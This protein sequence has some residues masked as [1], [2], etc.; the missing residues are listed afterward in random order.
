MVL[1]TLDLLG[2]GALFVVTVGA[3]GAWCVAGGEVIGAEG[4]FRGLAAEGWFAVLEASGLVD[5]FWTGNGFSGAVWVASGFAEVLDGSGGSGFIGAGSA[6][7][8]SAVSW[9]S[10]DVAGSWAVCR[11]TRASVPPTASSAVAPAA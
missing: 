3:V 9:V 10:V 7:G 4:G 2:A 6:L 1:N 11:M 8:D 5:S